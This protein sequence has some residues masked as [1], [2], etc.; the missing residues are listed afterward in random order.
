MKMSKVLLWRMKE[1]F[2][3]QI[4]LFCFS[5]TSSLLFTSISIK[6]VKMIIEIDARSGDEQN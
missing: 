4:V 5:T 6:I 3:L 1:R 2:C